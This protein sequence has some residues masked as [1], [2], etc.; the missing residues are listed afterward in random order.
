MSLMMLKPLTVLPTKLVTLLVLAATWAHINLN[1][2][3]KGATTQQLGRWQR[4]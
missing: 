4:R 2:I 1:L 3:S